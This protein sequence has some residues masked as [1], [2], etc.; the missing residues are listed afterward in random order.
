VWRGLHQYTIN[1][2]KVCYIGNSA[3]A[4]A[5]LETNSD[6]STLA[7]HY[8][9]QLEQSGCVLN[10]EGQ[11]GPLAWITW[12]LKVDDKQCHG[13]FIILKEL[14]QEYYLHLRMKSPNGGKTTT[15]K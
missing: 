9:T 2:N 14:D 4:D 11:D 3:H 10:E 6:L 15:E 13:F 8:K 1:R 12:T 5:I 7:A